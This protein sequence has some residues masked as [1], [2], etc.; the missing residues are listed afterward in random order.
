MFLT[1][2]YIKEAKLYYKLREHDT[3]G[4]GGV[5]IAMLNEIL[6]SDESF[7]FPTN[8]LSSVFK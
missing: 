8:A 2:L 6:I 4:K 5:T 3:E 1:Q 7:K